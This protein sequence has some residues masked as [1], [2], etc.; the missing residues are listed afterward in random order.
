MVHYDG[1]E[2]EHVRLEGP[3]APEHR[4]LTSAT[5][6]P[7]EASVAVRELEEEKKK[8]KEEKK[9]QKSKPKR[10]RAKTSGPKRMRKPDPRRVKKVL[11]ET[12]AAAVEAA[13]EA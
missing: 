8:K 2:K 3:K 6:T 12:A 13:A 4:W 1:G 11:D 7:G 10:K 9:N 5:T